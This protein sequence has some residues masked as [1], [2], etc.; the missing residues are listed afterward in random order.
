MTMTKDRA[1]TVVPHGL[2]SVEIRV[3]G[4]HDADLLTRVAPEVFDQPVDAR[5]ATEFLADPRH[6]LVVALDAGRIVAFASAVHYVHPDKPPELWVNEVGVAPTH[7]GQG[8]GRQLLEHLFAHGRALDCREAWVL[9]E[10]ENES[11]RRLYERVGGVES[12][13]IMY[14]F[15]LE[16]GR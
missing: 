3:L 10:P 9:T 2:M 13:T 8:I 12:Q 11:A 16:P 7:Q 6:H 5:F 4:P 15:R 1:A 14:T